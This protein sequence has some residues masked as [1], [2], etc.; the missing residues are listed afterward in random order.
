VGQE[1]AGGSIIARKERRIHGVRGARW[2]RLRSGRSLPR[3]GAK[4]KIPKSNG[5]VEENGGMEEKVLAALCE[6]LPSDARSWRKARLQELLA[7]AWRSGLFDAADHWIDS[8]ADPYAIE[9][10]VLIRALAQHDWG[11]AARLAPHRGR[12]RAPVEDGGFV[13]ALPHCVRF[14]KMA[15]PARLVVAL[16]VLEAALAGG[17]DVS[18]RDGDRSLL[19]S[20]MGHER[21]EAIEILAR[22]GADVHERRA[23]GG[24]LLHLAALLGDAPSCEALLGLGV[25]P[26]ARDGEGRL[27]RERVDGDLPPKALARMAE[28][29]A[30][31]D[32]DELDAT[33]RQVGAGRAPRL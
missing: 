15:G 13:G 30:K 23:D 11:R 32:R 20:L 2:A 16:G 7:Y 33:V 8:G 24:T 28:L 25:D 3:G 12:E 22:H 21:P 10:P 1:G 9:A 29:W 17:A 31:S 27:A 26:N 18:D 4:D 6:S 5:R 19:A 14:A